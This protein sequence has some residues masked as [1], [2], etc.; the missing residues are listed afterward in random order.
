MSLNFSLLLLRVFLLPF[1][2]PVS[3]IDKR[4]A[5]MDVRIWELVIGAL[6]NDIGLLL[7]AM[8]STFHTK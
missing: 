5:R 4:I 7:V 2:P 6:L 1:F 3:H 8:F